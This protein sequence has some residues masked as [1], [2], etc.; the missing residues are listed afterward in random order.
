[1]NSMMAAELFGSGG[2]EK[3][4]FWL[5]TG[6]SKE[7]S[8]QLDLGCL[9][10]APVRAKPRSASPWRMV[11]LPWLLLLLLGLVEIDHSTG[12][13]LSVECLVGAK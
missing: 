1:M 5:V 6:T 2:E 4:A 13:L 12:K 3:A 11:L 7:T 8:E 10:D 9:A